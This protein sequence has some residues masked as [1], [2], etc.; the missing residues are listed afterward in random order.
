MLACPLMLGSGVDRGLLGEEAS[1]AQTGKV[2]GAEAW[3]PL[4]AFRPLALDD[5]AIHGHAVR[6]GATEPAGGHEAGEVGGGGM[7]LGV[8]HHFLLARASRASRSRRTT[9][10]HSA[11][12]SSGW[13]SSWPEPAYS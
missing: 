9:R 13:I 11:Q 6:L 10:M 1:Q 4:G 2:A 12:H 5:L 7:L 8:G 3:W